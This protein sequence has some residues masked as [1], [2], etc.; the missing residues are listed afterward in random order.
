[1]APFKTVYGL[2]MAAA[3]LTAIPAPAQA[4]KPD[5]GRITVAI[6]SEPRDLDP[7]NIISSVMGLVLRQNVVETLTV[8]DPEDSR[9]LPKLATKWEQVD[10]ATWRFTLRSGVKFHDGADFDAAAAA[11]AIERQAIPDLVCTSRVK[12]PNT[13]L[14]TKVVDPLT[15][16][17]TASPPE[18][19]LPVFLSFVGMSSP[20][21]K[22]EKSREPVGTGPFAFRE[23]VPTQ[24]I[25]VD[26]FDSYW[27]DKPQI[28]GV[29]Y[30]WRKESALRAAM[31]DT[32]E[33]D[34]AVDI[35][36]QDATDP[37]RDFS[38]FNGETTRI[39]MVLQPPLDDIRVRKAMNLALDRQALIGTLLSKDVV[40][41]TQLILPKVIGHNP[42]LKPWPYDLDAAKKLIE[43][44]KADG[45]PVDKEIRLI[46]RVGYYPNGE[47]VLQALVQ[48]WGDLGLNLKLE[49]MEPAQWNKIANKPYDA[50]RPAMLIQEMHDNNNGDAAFTLPF[51]FHTDG[52][53]SEISN[54]ELDK[55]LRDASLASG[56]ERQKLFQEA[57]RVIAEDIV[58]DVVMYH[59]V[60]MMRVSPLIDFRPGKQTYSGMLEIAPA[61]I[62]GN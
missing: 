55:L 5:S 22:A 47:E 13:T 10:D 3:V 30:T 53:H 35:A 51:K 39:R 42:E 58:A 57:N 28:G 40:P 43:E 14:T 31:V 56:E 4:Q 9:P 50:N 45:V 54:P 36:P 34:L 46:G 25:E 2:A 1:M 48:M 8:L 29:T 33:A 12:L 59:M 32:G 52:G 37:A 49:M 24:R 17:I 18:P 21:T 23:W 61:R 38:Y 11:K 41:A 62:V 20:N 44:A 7:C 16:D 26:R 19:L 15:L 6:A 27:G 60:S